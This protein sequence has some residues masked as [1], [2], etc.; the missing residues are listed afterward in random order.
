MT[1]EKYLPAE[2]A[3]WLKPKM[4]AVSDITLIRDKY[5]FITCKGITL[6]S[7]Y[8]VDGDT[9]DFVINRM[10][11][12]SVYANQSTLRKGYITLEE[13][14]RV[15]FV[16]ELTVSERDKREYL[17]NIS[18]LNIRISRSI[19]DAAKDIL[20]HIKSSFG[21][22]NSL[23]VAP[24]GAGKTTVLKDIAK[25]L[26]K[27]YRVGVVDERGELSPCEGKYSFSVKGISKKDGIVLLLRSMAPEV[28][29]TDE[30][31]TDE[32]EEAIKKLLNAG[33]KII[34]TAH[35]YD[36]KDILRREVF[37]NLI[38]SHA[39]DRVIAISRRNGP[40]TIEKIINTLELR[41]IV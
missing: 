7:P 17:R 41:N 11:N 19:K 20:P 9:L 22:F 38:L 2:F 36:E 31:G 26:G 40:G 10:C 16:G 1:M 37:K 5:M 35:G 12:Q 27:D 3:L 8:Y 18:G 32:D 13:G 33:V 39:F 21:V 15:G 14:H 30:I 6:S 24:P 28:I 4:E 23:I 29:I 34:C 25:E